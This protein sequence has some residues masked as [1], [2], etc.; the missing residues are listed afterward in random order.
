MT[1]PQTISVYCVTG[2]V[3]GKPGLAGGAASWENCFFLHHTTVLCSAT[4]DQTST[5]TP[6]FETRIL[7][8][9]ELY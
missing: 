8:C 6:V 1:Y 9:L 2:P 5:A 4:V 3:S 7:A